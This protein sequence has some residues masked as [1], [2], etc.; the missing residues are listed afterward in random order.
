MSD[1]SA[2]TSA[3]SSAPGKAAPSPAAAARTRLL[4]EGPI[5]PTLLRLAAPNVLT[6]LAFAGV[7]TFDGFFLGRIGTNALAGALLAFP[8]VMVILQTTNITQGN[9]SEA[10]ASALVPMR[11]RKNPSNV[12]TP[13]NASKVRM[14]GAARRSS[15]GKIGPLSRSLVRAAVDGA[16]CLAGAGDGGEIETLLLFIGNSCALGGPAALRAPCM[17]DVSSI[18]LYATRVSKIISVR[19]INHL[20]AGCA[21][22]R[23]YGAGSVPGRQLRCLRSPT[24]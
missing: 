15:V 2:P 4:L 21:L 18:G 9:A 6:L 16:T 20:D 14:F 12:I 23:R 19:E 3:P 8:W 24:R 7:I 10:P 13:A 5:L 1:R 17:R 22:R 11:P